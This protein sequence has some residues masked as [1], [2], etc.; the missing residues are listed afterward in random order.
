MTMIPTAQVQSES[1]LAAVHAMSRREAIKRAALFLGVA[2]SPALITR[3]LAAAAPNAGPVASSL[4]AQQAELVAAI[5]ERI[6]PRSDTPGAV[7]VGVPVFI[8]VMVGKYLSAEER[9]MFLA[10]LADVDARSRAAHQRGFAQLTAEQQDALLMKIAEASMAQEKTFFHQMKELTVV[11]YFTSEKV[12]RNVLH[13]D[14]VPG[15]YQSSVPISEVGNVN[16]TK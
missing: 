6:L 11:G 1:D 15:R 12:G 10:G 3:A 4:N 13:Y 9:R 14:P 5:A 2:L 7:D 8:D 16:W